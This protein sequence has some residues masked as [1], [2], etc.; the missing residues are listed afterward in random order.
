MYKK[1]W[2]KIH[3]ILGVTA[4]VILLII[5]LT[6]SI[7]SFEKEILDV[8]NKKSYIVE[9][10]QTQKLT[11]SQ[12]LTQF[13]EKFPK[14][15]IN[16]ITFSQAK[17]SSVIINIAGEGK[18]ARRGINYY[19]NPYNAEI[20]P[21]IQGHGFFKFIENIHRRLAMGEVG[22]QIVG[23]ST[24]CLFLLMF[25]GVY[26]YW[27]K[28][29]KSFFK[30]FTFSFDSKGRGFLA[31]IH[32]SLGLWVIP[33]YLVVSITGLYWSYSWFNAGLYKIAGVEKPQRM[34][35]D[36]NTQRAD[37]NQKGVSYNE[38]ENVVTLFNQNVPE[39]E[40][41]NLK[42]SSKKGVYTINYID[43][44]STHLRARNTM[45]INTHSNTIQSN[46]K[47]ID[48]PLNERLM[49]SIYALHTGEYFGLTGKIIMFISSLLMVLFTVT[50]VMMYLKRKKS[51]RK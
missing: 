50:G 38:I 35:R 29:K 45:M 18:S 36:T 28:M 51:V 10:P 41:A 17:D 26:L 8:V 12:L 1:N 13:K 4:G 46:E 9:V 14:A 21:S 33:M 3:L 39:Y 49:K 43:E 15:K 37:K 6:G 25:S 2:F 16:G 48:L 23:A 7:L 40:K 34:K 5:G 20:L 11:T 42:F 27:K 31:S 32:S 22:K 44:S 47:F 30:S 24:L 19:V